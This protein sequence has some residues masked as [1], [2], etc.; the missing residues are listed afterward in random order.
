MRIEIKET[1]WE[2]V[3]DLGLA[4]QLVLTPNKETNPE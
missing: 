2:F 1:E 3:V 4:D